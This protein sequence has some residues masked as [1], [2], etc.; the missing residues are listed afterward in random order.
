MARAQGLVEYVIL[1]GLVALVLAVAVRFFS[2]TVGAA[3]VGVGDRLE[4][5]VAQP[6]GAGQLGPSV[7]WGS[8]ATDPATGTTRRRLRREGEAASGR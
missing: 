5:E 2:G 4:A 6:V 3:W 7:T 1:V 8:S